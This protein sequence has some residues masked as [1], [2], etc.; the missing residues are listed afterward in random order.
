MG[1]KMKVNKGVNKYIFLCAVIISYLY[2][3]NNQDK[4]VVTAYE[5]AGQVSLDRDSIRICSQNIFR[6]G[7]R[8]V[9]SRDFDSQAEAL[10][11]RIKNVRCEVVALQEIPGNME[12]SKRVI[13][14]FVR[15]LDSSIGS[16]V[17][18]KEI[19][20]QSNDS[21][22]RNGLLYNELL[23][24]VH[25]VT[26]MYHDSLPRLSS[27]SAPWSYARGPLMVE[28]R[29]TDSNQK[30]LVLINYHQKSKS[31]GFKDKTGLDFELFRLASAGGIRERIDDFM[32]SNSESYVEVLLGDRNSETDSASALVLSGELDMEDFRGSKSCEILPNGAPDCERYHFSKPTFVPVLA[33]KNK[34]ESNQLA[35]HRYRSNLSI[36]D[37]IYISSEDSDRVKADNGRIRAGT[38]GEFGEGSDHLL[39]W[40]EVSL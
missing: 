12:Q 10:V 27:N 7:D 28:L 14:K 33:S 3:L 16:K 39:S 22:I 34:D 26:N 25:N 35:T 4:K 13:E 31:K 15:M 2:G 17:S 21:Y 37:E 1:S 38:E 40:I 32:K 36:L 30:G 19:L 8:G 9:D 18:Y 29:L 24:K 11:R 6:L 5:A 20:A 23:F